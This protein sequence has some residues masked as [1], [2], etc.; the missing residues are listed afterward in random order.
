MIS[1]DTACTRAVA[2]RVPTSVIVGHRAGNPAHTAVPPASS[3]RHHRRPKYHADAR[4][5]ENPTK[6]FPLTSLEILLIFQT[7]S[8][9]FLFLSFSFPFP[10]LLIS[11][12]H[13][14]FF[15]FLFLLSF[16]P[17]FFSLSLPFFFLGLAMLPL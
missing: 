4:K 8:F 3:P 7:S 15:F 16:F 17:F 2:H 13:F 10:I 12:P 14:P 5:P 9:L 11:F 6:S 1:T